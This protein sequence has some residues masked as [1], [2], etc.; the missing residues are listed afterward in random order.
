MLEMISGKRVFDRNRPPG[1]QNLVEWAK[2]YLF[3]KHR[4]LQ[5]FDHH[6]KG[7]FSVAR[8]LKAVDL[9]F[10]CLSRD[11]KLRPNMN[12]VVKILEKLQE[13]SDM[14]GLGISQ[15]KRRQIR[16]SVQSMVPNTAGE[17]ALEPAIQHP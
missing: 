7:Q 9:A 14:D 6:I 1:E 8:A 12:N 5:I 11:P 2:P 3:S 4:V 13:Y 16:M 15:N 10:L 17:V